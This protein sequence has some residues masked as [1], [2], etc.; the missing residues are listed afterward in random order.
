MLKRWWQCGDDDGDD[1]VSCQKL[2]CC[3]GNGVF[4]KSV[5]SVVVVLE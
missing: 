5:V 3:D 1:G 4:L 2:W